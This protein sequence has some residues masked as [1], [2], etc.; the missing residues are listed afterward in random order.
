MVD[1]W[2]LE[3]IKPQKNCQSVISKYPLGSWSK[4]I[5]TDRTHHCTKRLSVSFLTSP[6]PP[7]PSNSHLFLT[8]KNRWKEWT[9]FVQ[10]VWKICKLHMHTI[11]EGPLS[12]FQANN[13][14]SIRLKR[15]LVSCIASPLSVKVGP[16]WAHLFWPLPN[17][18]NL[19]NICNCFLA[20]AWI[21]YYPLY[22]K[23]FHVCLELVIW[24]LPGLSI[25]KNEKDKHRINRVATHQ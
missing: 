6:P 15:L 17:S 9:V 18:F 7:F 23:Y 12:N 11:N 13:M 25:K 3:T 1:T 20:V 10:F 2:D 14:Y 21:N 22:R 16:P 5:Y 24:L 19:L 4:L 8:V